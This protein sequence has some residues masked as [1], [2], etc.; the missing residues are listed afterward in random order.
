[1]AFPEVRRI[2]R[3]DDVSESH[4]KQLFVDAVPQETTSNYWLFFH[5]LHASTLRCPFRECVE[6]ISIFSVRSATRRL[7][8]RCILQYGGFELSSV[9]SRSETI[10]VFSLNE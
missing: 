5:M 2:H 9:L 6:I 4:E 8:D 3:F 1:M 10:A 7:C